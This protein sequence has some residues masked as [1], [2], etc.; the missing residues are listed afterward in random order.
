ELGDDD[1]GRARL[2]RRA[3]ERERLLRSGR[4]LLERDAARRVAVLVGDD[5]RGARGRVGWLRAAE[6]CEERR[7]DQ[8]S[9]RDPVHDAG[10]T[11]GFAE[12]RGTILAPP[13]EVLMSKRIKYAAKGGGELEAE[14]GEPEGT[15]KAPAL[16]LIQE[17]WGVNDHIRSLVDR[18]AKEGF[19]T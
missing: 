10:L 19:L 8:E 6:R 15:G 13:R 3:R 5:A 7:E 11:P 2:V 14:I 17:W 1:F 16:I 12:D 4:A 9:R 18:F